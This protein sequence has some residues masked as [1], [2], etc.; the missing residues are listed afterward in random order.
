MRLPRNIS[1][2]QLVQMLKKLGYDKTRQTGS[3]ARLT[4]NGPPQHHLTIPM[5]DEIRIGTL[6]S[7]LDDVANAQNMSKDSLVIG[8][9]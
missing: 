2:N 4:H 8:L 3:H 5:H 1:G 6:S 7:I 9:S